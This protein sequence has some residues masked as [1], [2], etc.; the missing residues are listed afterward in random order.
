[1]NKWVKAG[2]VGAG[3]SLVMALVMFPAIQ[4]GV[5]PF[6]LPPSAA[7][8]ERLGLNVGPLALVAHFGYGIFW[9]I[10]FVAL[11]GERADVKRALGLAATLWL[12]LMVIYSPAIGWGVFGFGAADRAADH[13]L[14]LGSPIKYA[15]AT[16]LLHAVYG[17]V[18]GTLNPAWATRGEDIAVGATS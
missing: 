14:H 4:A 3:G 1:M 10:V 9:S 7:L 18:I 15:V 5:A 12:I 13:P 16:L 2:L 11:F 8:L 6:N 17:L